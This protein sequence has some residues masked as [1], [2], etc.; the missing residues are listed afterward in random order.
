MVEKKKVFISYKRNVEPDEHIA[1]AI[2]SQLSEI[3]DVF[4]DQKMMV[5]TK[6]S[7]EIKENL[8]KSDFF[9]SLISENSVESDMV[10]T[11]IL[12]AYK[13]A[14]LTGSPVILPVRLN[15]F[16]DLDYDLMAY[17]GSSNYIAWG[18]HSDTKDVINQLCQAID[19]YKLSDERVSDIVNQRTKNKEMHNPEHVAQLIRSMSHS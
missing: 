18:S 7:K 13:Q 1:L 5:G 2:Y 19:G 3:Y 6:W 4:I 12:I 16:G 9:I 8:L 17:L 15:Y 10:S 14:K 11:E